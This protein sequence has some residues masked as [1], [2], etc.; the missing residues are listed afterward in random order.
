MHSLQALAL[1]HEKR[2]ARRRVLLDAD[3]AQTVEHRLAALERHREP[4]PMRVLAA[5][6]TADQELRDKTHGTAA[7]SA[8]TGA[9]ATT[10]RPPSR[11]S[12]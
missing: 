1:M 5:P 10:G 3:A 4:V 6:A 9:R 2:K 11:C 8:R 7:V 12:V